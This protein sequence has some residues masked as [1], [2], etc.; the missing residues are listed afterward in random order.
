MPDWVTTA[1]AIAALLL[2]VW[3]TVWNYVQDR[4][5]RPRL[6]LSFNSVGYTHLLLFEATADD[7]RD[8]ELYI[9]AANVSQDADLTITT[10]GYRR[11]GTRERCPVPFLV[12]GSTSTLIDVHQ[13]PPDWPSD[14]RI[15]LTPSET[16]MLIV[17]AAVL[18]PSEELT[19]IYVV[20]SR[21][22]VTR[23]PQR[24]LRTLKASHRWGGKCH[25]LPSA[26][27]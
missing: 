13:K 12:L 20:C 27:T 19:G 2:S 3:N 25:S 4:A 17:R 23:L 15:K 24:E 18:C 7:P 8:A 5:R 21:G 9:D 14:T 6:R 10:V 16:A 22:R 11:R 1:L 26:S